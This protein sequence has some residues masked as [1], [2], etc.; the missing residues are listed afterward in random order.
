MRG[1]IEN[2]GSVASIDRTA[3]D[4]GAQKAWCARARGEAGELASEPS[5]QAIDR[6]LR[7]VARR[8]GAL[9]AEEAQLLCRAVREEIWRA[10]GTASLLEYVEEVLGH[11]PRA[12]RERVRVALALDELPELADALAT[13]ELA[14]SAVRELSRVATPMT[15]AAWCARARG[16]NLRQIEELVSGRTR[17]DLPDDPPDPDLVP[18]VLR[19]EV[20][21]ATYALVRQAQ[22][23]LADELGQFV[24]DDALIAAM[25]HAVLERRGERDAGRDDTGRARYQI[26][27]VVCEACGQGWHEG[28][29]VRCALD[30]A[31]LARAECDAQR[32]GSDAEPG[33]AVQDVP[34]R[35]QRFVRRRDGGRCCVPGCRASRHLELHHVVPREAGGGHGP[36]NLTLLCDGHHRAL[37]EGKVTITG[38]APALE[39]RWR[40]HPAPPTPMPSRTDTG[41]RDPEIS[42]Y[43][44]V[45]LKTQAKQALVTLRFSK[46]EAA[47]AVEAAATHVGREPTLE[48]LIFEALRRCPRPI[49]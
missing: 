32:V 28:G 5:W 42:R 9:D 33:R 40:H 22:Q 6:A 2:I 4:G 26:M 20:R 17:G 38:K 14:F 34:P 3:S 21:P 29:G 10:V 7:E 39:V 43:A 37:H 8:R 48:R 23:A 47:T 19:Y 44:L 46:P 16:Q 25:C 49:R 35:I 41:P 36:E 12:A 18:K 13:G 27:T 24:D 15:Q 45:A 31:D 11:G 1:A 30:P